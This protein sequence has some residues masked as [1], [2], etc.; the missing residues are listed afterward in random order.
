MEPSTSTRGI[1]LQEIGQT[2]PTVLNFWSAQ[3]QKRVTASDLQQ[4]QALWGRIIRQGSIGYESWVAYLFWPLGA[5]R[6][7]CTFFN[8]RAG[9]GCICRKNA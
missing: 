9:R 3:A 5:S 4:V 1:T 8:H 7:V 6:N 2:A